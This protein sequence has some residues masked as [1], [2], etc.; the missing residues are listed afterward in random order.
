M[1][2]VT[3]EFL[4]GAGMLAVGVIAGWLSRKKTNAPSPL[5]DPIL[6]IASFAVFFIIIC[7]SISGIGAISDIRIVSAALL[8]LGGY[9]L[10][11][12][13]SAPPK[14]TAICI[15]DPE[16]GG[17][18]VQDIYHCKKGEKQYLIEPGLS[19]VIKAV[20]G[21]SQEIVLDTAVPHYKISVTVGNAEI[22]NV[23]LIASIEKQDI[24]DGKTKNIYH[25]AQRMW[26]RPEA[27]Y[28]DLKSTDSAISEAAELRAKLTR[29][30][31]EYQA[32]RSEGITDHFRR[33]ISFDTVSPD[34][35]SRLNEIVNEVQVRRKEESDAGTADPAEN[36]T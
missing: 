7:G 8:F 28:Y 24:G 36:S 3:F 17:L 32:A 34:L 10:G 29:M 19:G 11:F 31:I 30:D 2:D 35:L 33:M 27:Y 9:V 12:L 20:M 14:V 4:A 6:I 25:M 22:P 1:A 5:S 21:H 13:A 18:S 16:T 26:E 15:R 23:V